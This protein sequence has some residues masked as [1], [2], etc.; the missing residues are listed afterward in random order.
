MLRTCQLNQIVHLKSIRSFEVE[1]ALGF[2]EIIHGNFDIKLTQ[3][4]PQVTC[5]PLLIADYPVCVGSQNFRIYCFRISQIVDS[6]YWHD[7]VG[8]DKPF[9][10]ALINSI[11]QLH[12]LSADQFIISINNKHNATFLAM[13]EDRQNFVAKC[14]DAMLILY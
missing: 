3:I 6:L 13:V 12:H 9:S 1:V 10:S 5:H 14:S 11:H 8:V 2:H 4:S 7:K